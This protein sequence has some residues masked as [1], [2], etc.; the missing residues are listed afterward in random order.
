MNHLVAAGFNRSTDNQYNY[1]DAGIQYKIAISTGPGPGFVTEN[2]DY[3]SIY[4]GNSF[5][6]LDNLTWSRGR[7]T[8]KAGA[9]L[10]HIQMNQSYGK[11]GTLTF[12]KLANLVANSVNKA[13]L[14]GSMPVNHLRK[15]DIIGYL[16]DEFKVRPNLN[17]NLGLHYTVFQIFTEAEGLANPFDFDTCGAQGL[18]GVGASFGQQNYGDFDPRVGLARS[19]DR[20]GHTVVRSGFGMYH[21]DGQLDDQNL[22]AKNEVPS[23]PATGCSSSPLPIPESTTQERPTAPE[24]SSSPE[25]TTADSA[26][27]PSHGRRIK[28]PDTYVE[29][30]SLSVQRELPANF[31]G[32]VSYLGSH[33]VHLLEESYV[34]LIT[35][36]ATI[37]QYAA[38]APAIGWRGSIGM[39]TYNGLSVAMSVPCRTASWWRLITRIRTKSIT[40]PTAA[41]MAT[42]FN[43]R[44]CCAR[45]VKPPAA[46]GMPAM[47]SKSR[48]S[49]VPSGIPSLSSHVDEKRPTRLISSRIGRRLR[50]KDATATTLQGA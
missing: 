8:V 18:C 15:N 36:P 23:Y 44:I 47:W 10:R 38:F 46:P 3:D 6:Y 13:K 49:S 34:N 43:R 17:F 2:Y 21:E 22:P 40:D 45:P 28:G 14:T 42:R 48:G 4:V 32:T 39:S 19:P 35:P 25:P 27:E 30:W 26:P 29:Q 7:R 24:R 11:P 37:P 16:E 41:A 20:G 9:E 33:G 12:S 5:S 31:V 50:H 1:S